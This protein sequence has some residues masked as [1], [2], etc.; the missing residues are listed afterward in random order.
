MYGPGYTCP[1]SSSLAYKHRNYFTLDVKLFK[2]STPVLGY[3]FCIQA[4]VRLRIVLSCDNFSDLCSSPPRQNI[5]PAIKNAA[6]W[7][8]LGVFVPNIPLSHNFSSSSF[9]N[10]SVCWTCW[11]IPSEGKVWKCT[12]RVPWSSLNQESFLSRQPGLISLMCLSTLVSVKL[13]AL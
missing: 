8:L 7:R 9:V 10:T 3:I 4:V 1:F 11:P 13:T 5:L 12:S 6:F 2:G